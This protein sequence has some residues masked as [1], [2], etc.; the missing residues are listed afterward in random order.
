[1]SSDNQYLELSVKYLLDNKQIEKLEKIRKNL[2]KYPRGKNTYTLEDTFNFVMMQGSKH[3][4]DD[5]LKYYESYLN[6]LLEDG[7]EIEM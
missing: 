4:I 5:N 7:E 6:A 2:E 3:V 1:M